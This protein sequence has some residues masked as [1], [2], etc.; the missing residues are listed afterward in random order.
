MSGKPCTDR[1]HVDVPN[2]PLQDEVAK[3]RGS[4]ILL[5]EG[6]SGEAVLFIVITGVLS[7]ELPHAAREVFAAAPERQVKVVRHQA[8]G[9]MAHAAAFASVAKHAVES[10][11]ILLLV[12][13]LQAS[14]SPQ[15]DMPIRHLQLVPLH[16]GGT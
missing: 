7:V 9:N 12:K 5:L 16:W 6:V 15:C 11:V 14:C 4:V 10:R 13:E 8:V 3:D 2:N 1:V